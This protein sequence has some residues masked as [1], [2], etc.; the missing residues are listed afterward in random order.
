[1]AEAGITYDLWTQ[2]YDEKWL[3]KSC[4]K[5][6]WKMAITEAIQ[7]YQKNIMLLGQLAGEDDFEAAR[8]LY[9][10]DLNLQDAIT[11]ITKKKAEAE[12][13]ERE[14]IR[15]AAEEAAKAQARVEAETRQ[16]MQQAE[17]YAREREAVVRKEEQEAAQKQMQ[18]K[19]QEMEQQTYLRMQKQMQRQ[20]QAMPVQRAGMSYQT[21]IPTGGS[22]M[23]GRWAAATSGQGMPRPAYGI[24]QGM[25]R[26]QPVQRG[27]APIQ[28]S[29]QQP[30]LQT[31]AAELCTFTVHRV[32][33]EEVCQF[34][35]QRGIGYHIH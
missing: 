19:Q 34:L 15:I 4:S 35:T 12:A 26:Q 27:N 21:G 20:T 23:S 7:S 14:R 29:V 16:V 28:R 33:Q 3:N 6:K 31:Q 13:L 18:Q 8:K 2:I 17:S 32:H 10:V 11:Y 1:M 5:K 24:R 30:I 9:E 22:T 25:Q